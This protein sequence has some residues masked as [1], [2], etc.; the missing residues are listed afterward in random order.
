M[1]EK[2]RLFDIKMS[3]VDVLRYEDALFSLFSELCQ[4][5]KNNNVVTW[6]H[7][8]LMKDLKEYWAF[9]L[10]DQNF[11]NKKFSLKEASFVFFKFKHDEKTKKIISGMI[12]H[13]PYYG[14]LQADFFLKNDEIDKAK[15]SLIN[16]IC[17]SKNTKVMYPGKVK[18][19]F[20]QIFL[21]VI[22]NLNLMIFSPAFLT[23]F[24]TILEEKG[25]LMPRFKS[26]LSKIFTETQNGADEKSTSF[27]TEILEY[28]TICHASLSEEIDYMETSY[29]DDDHNFDFKRLLVPSKGKPNLLIKHLVAKL[30]CLKVHR[31]NVE[32]LLESL[33]GPDV[34]NLAIGKRISDYLKNFVPDTKEERQTR[35]LMTEPEIS[36]LGSK[37]LKTIYGLKKIDTV[38]QPQ[39]VKAKAQILGALSIIARATA[40]P[41]LAFAVAN[42]ASVM[43]AEAIALVVLTLFKE[44]NNVDDLVQKTEYL[45]GTLKNFLS[46]L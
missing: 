6:G 15:A 32:I 46:H 12:S 44:T 2:D 10:E 26:F 25:P 33:E 1:I 21:I 20:L 14:V 39:M 41:P 38:P 42:V 19:Y 16:A 17:L 37:G 43:V 30:T 45:K 13:N 29:F 40:F 4:E 8:Y 36:E 11:E 31:S 28:L 18:F 35:D 3:K 23:L 22:S 5:L 34:H 24:D 7:S 9:W 27:L